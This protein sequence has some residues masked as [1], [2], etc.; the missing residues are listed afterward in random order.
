MSVDKP[1]KNRKT[2]ASEK[3]A[4]RT[5]QRS[6]VSI[7]SEHGPL[8]STISHEAIAGRAYMLFLARGGQPGD[9]RKDWFQA[10]IE[11]RREGSRG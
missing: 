9:D 8:T 3:L 7:P 11:L 10:E 6:P 2:K 1:G 4:V 5:Q